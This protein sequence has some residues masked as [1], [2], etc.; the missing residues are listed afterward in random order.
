MML[1]VHSCLS[2]STNCSYICGDLVQ[3]LNRYKA[4]WNIDLHLKPVL[5]M[6]VGQAA[7]TIA[8]AM[9]PNRAPYLTKDLLRTA[10][11]FNVPL[12]MPEVNCMLFMDSHVV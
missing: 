4:Y 12:K 6:G 11:Y 7:G 3:I 10:T 2:L 8:P 1:L 9:K 5:L